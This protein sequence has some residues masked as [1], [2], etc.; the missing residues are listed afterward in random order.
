M[1]QAVIGRPEASEYVAYYEKYVS[2]APEED[3]AAAL[4]NDRKEMLSLVGS[5]PES[6]A[7]HRYEPGKWSIR[8]AVQHVVDTERVFGFR[9]FWFSR[10]ISLSLPSFDQDDAVKGAPAATRL[11]GVAAE[12]DRVRQGHVLLFRALEPQ[13]WTRTGVASGNPVSVRAL[14]AII[15][16]HC[17]HHAGILRERYL[18]A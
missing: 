6:R 9:A 1:S 3:L 13:A 2:K 18:T 8:E 14:A 4:E 17:R 10:G 12:F 11:S 7:D 16:G 5:I 15:V